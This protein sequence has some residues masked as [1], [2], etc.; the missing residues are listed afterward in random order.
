MRI[1]AMPDD[2]R[3]FIEGHRAFFILSHQEPDGDCIGS[4]LALRSFLRRLGK[5]A[6]AYN[7][8]PFDRSE[9]RHFAQEFSSHIPEDVLQEYPDAGVFVVDS[10]SFDRVGDLRDQIR[11]F[12]IAVIDHH[13]TG[14]PFGQ[15]H[16]IAPEVPSTTLLIQQIIEGFGH[17]PTK[18]EADLLFLGLA[19]DTGFFQFI[20]AGAGDVFHAA[21]RLVDIGTSP[22]HMH[23]SI[24]DN[25]SV[26]SRK[27]LA[28]LLER[29]E[30]HMDGK[31]YLSYAP[32]SD[33]TEFGKNERDSDSLYFLLLNI[34]ECEAVAFLREIGDGITVGS[35]RSVEYI[36]VSTIAHSFGGGGHTRAA[37]FKTEQHL[38]DVKNQI[39]EKFSKAFAEHAQS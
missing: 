23:R 24:N 14:H 1:P 18:E 9:I 21:G 36:D 19:T 6:E 27:H 33:E 7:E 22:R 38:S 3:A 32:L 29:A 34:R 8:G 20:N 25:R 15:V 11:A 5:F 4:S 37:G 39:L 13:M 2:I 30:S 16:M 10:S 17:T 28:R 35:L 12:P 26:Q 31:L